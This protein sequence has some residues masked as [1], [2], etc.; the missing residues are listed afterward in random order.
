M[1]KL[2]TICSIIGSACC[3]SP[4]ISA[5]S[6]DNAI[7]SAGVVRKHQSQ[8]DKESSL[9]GKL[10]EVESKFKVSIL[11]DADLVKNKKV[12]ATNKFSTVEE[13]LKNLLEPFE[14]DYKKGEDGLFV[15]IPKSNKSLKPIESNGSKI[16]ETR[17]LESELT[18]LEFYASRGNNIIRADVIISGTVTGGKEN[19]PLPGV[20]VQLKGTSIGTATDVNGKYTLKLPDASGV[21]VF[22]YIGYVPEEVSV[23]NKTVIDIVLIEDIT[24]L[25]EVVVVGYGTQSRKNL[26]SSISTLKP[27]D[28]NRGAISDV[29]QLLQGKVPGLNISR[30]GDPNRPAAIIMRGASTLREGAQSPLFVIDGVIGADISLI[31]PDDIASMEVLKDAAA[32]AIYGNRAANG[33]IMVTTKRG[34]AG[35]MQI[36][37]SSYLAADKVSNQY[38][39]M[40]ANQLRS[41]LETNGQSLAPQDDLGANTD[42]Q[43]EVQRKTAISHN[44]N[45]SIGGGTE[46]T[47][48]SASVNYFNQEGIIKGSS[49]ERFIGRLSVEQKALRDRLK[50]GISLTSSIN[51]ADLVPYRNT[52]LAQMLTYL[53]TS[54]VRRDD[55]TFFD[56]ITGNRTQYFNPVSMLENGEERS[57][58]N[59]LLGTFNAQLKLPFGFTYDVNVSYQTMQTNYGAYYN[60]YY[61]QYYNN[62]RN[63]PD[64]PASPVFVN[65][66]GKDGQAMR[67]TYQNTN[68]ILETFLTW[69]RDFGRHNINAVIGYSWQENTNGDGFQATSSNFPTDETGYS[70]LALGNPYGI[71]SFRVDYGS[72]T[73]YEQVRLISDF[74]RL[75]YN[76]DSR[77]L[78]QFSLRRDGSS[79]FG[80]NEQWGYFPSV[81]AAWRLSQESFIK[82]LNIFDDL[83][84][85][86]SH[87]V[88][89][90]SLGFN[91]YSSREIYNTQGKFYYQGTFVNAIGVVQNANPN[92]RWEK[93]STSNLGLDFSFFKGKL[94]GSLDV[95]N[96]RT[97]DLIYGYNVNTQIYPALNGI[98]T[99]NVGEMTNKGV[100]LSINATPLTLGDFSWTTTFNL[101]H[102]KNKIVSLSSDA[103]EKDSIALFQPDGGGQSGETVQMIASGQAL[104]TFY[105]YE[106]A[107]KDATGVSQYVDANGELTTKPQIIKDYKVLGNAQPK[108]LLGWS[109]NFR[110]KNLDLSVFFRSVIGNKIMNVTR[111]DL[112]RPSTAALNNIPVDVAS[113]SVND[114]NSHRYSSRFIEDGSYLRLDNATLGYNFKNLGQDIKQIRLYVSTNNL[115][116][117]TKYK[118]IDPEINQ[119]G[120]APGVDARNFYPKT[121]TFL[122]GINASF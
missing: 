1:Q 47:L 107:G 34:S 4:P 82:D 70:N 10:K 18:R 67:N 35:K 37:Y 88:T 15:I 62:I 92:L 55:G 111:A 41:F 63:T 73:V 52:V 26:T 78:L 103:F 81:G 21:L 33:V 95:Y 65:L 44:H 119:G 114:V 120:L 54:P 102:N 72:S 42:W 19:E 121:R 5:Q 108:V 56:N 85:R 27:E 68:K 50:L 66:T 24:S 36:S 45:I 105:T 87:G 46:K 76:Y 29:G 97:T 100:E 101:A 115:F 51:D 48:Y 16:E 69:N 75:N 99:A 9:S 23:S 117:I 71:P 58:Y 122:I 61:T 86:A 60:S 113:E 59:N 83:K 112:N 94:G 22:S 84:I 32:T 2:I 93:T 14:L 20:T 96:K 17:T 106:Y 98:L 91:A 38:D 64:P 79:A 53:P 28:M 116:V 31:A 3:I 118:G 109:N 49:L 43:D 6:A 74:G 8:S 40:D 104:G 25:K 77:Y 39:M 89:G 13:T 12:K 110:Y 30:S 90:N 7:A 11:Y 80:A 57:K